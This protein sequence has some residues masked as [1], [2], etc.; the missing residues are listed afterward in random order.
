MAPIPKSK[1]PT[2]PAF[3]AAA[4]RTHVE[5]LRNLAAG[6]DGILV[7]TTFHANPSVDKDGQGAMTYLRIGNVDGMVDAITADDGRST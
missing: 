7:V 1:Q 5:M 4:I 2:A 6:R 3:D